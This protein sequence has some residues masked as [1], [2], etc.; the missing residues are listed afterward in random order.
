MAAN[1]A[2]VGSRTGQ[3]PDPFLSYDHLRGGEP[4]APVAFDMIAV[5][6]GRILAK[7]AGTDRIFHLVMDELFRTYRVTGPDCDPRYQS[8]TSRSPSSWFLYEARPGVLCTRRA[9]VS[10]PA[11]AL[12]SY[13]EHP[14]DL[15][16]RLRGAAQIERGG[17]HAR[18]A[19]TARLVSRRRALAAHD[20]WSRRTSSLGRRLQG[21][22]HRSENSRD[23]RVD[24]RGVQDPASPAVRGRSEQE[25]RT[26][27][28]SITTAQLR[29]LVEDEIRGWAGDWVAD[30]AIEVFR[31]LLD[32]IINDVRQWLQDV[33]APMLANAI[34]DAI[35]PALINQLA[36][37]IRRSI[38]EDGFGSLLLP[39]NVLLLMSLYNLRQ[40]DAL[41]SGPDGE[42]SIYPGKALEVMTGLPGNEPLDDAIAELMLRARRRAVSAPQGGWPDDLPT[43]NH[44]PHWMPAYIHTRYEKPDG[45]SPKPRYAIVLRSARPRRR[46][47]PLVR[48]LA[49]ALRG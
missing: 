21:H 36:P 13:A 17:C 37:A 11:E 12:R 39:A 26:A 3:T 8:W 30:V 27:F 4:L 28:A 49:N 25:L 10:V 32:S 45:S 5:G 23:S 35:G 38:E 48:A 40:S 24:I 15:H 42:L 9:E 19:A 16:S 34:A 44:P 46:L 14:A 29:G 6:R 31:G 2:T 41:R 18:T 20:R 43:P 33:A 22:L 1:R 7:E 47:Q